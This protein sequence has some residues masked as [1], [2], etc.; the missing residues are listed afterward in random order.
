MKEKYHNGRGLAILAG[1]AATSGAIAL[2]LA[3]PLTTG[4]WTLDHGLVP[5]VV[6]LTVAS[7]HLA[8][9]AEG[10]CSRDRDDGHVLLDL[11]ALLV[12]GG[13]EVFHERIADAQF[14]GGFLETS[15]S[16]AFVS[17]FTSRNIGAI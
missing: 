6:G 16:D 12:P 7:G 5:L 3:E 13:V 8:T 15:R 11:P 1:I 17:R 9:R 14:V 2:L 4:H 10:R